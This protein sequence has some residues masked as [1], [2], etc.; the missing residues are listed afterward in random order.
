MEDDMGEPHPPL[1]TL[2]VA[3]SG[4]SCVNC[5]ILIERKFKNIAG[6]ERVKVDHARGYAEVSHAGDLDIATLQRAI[7]EDGYAVSP[8]APSRA[9]A[10]DKNSTRDYA[11]II[12]IFAVLLGTLFALQHFDLLPH[13]L[14][15]SDTMGYGLVF[16]IGLV[17]SVSSCM[18]VT[19]GLLVATAA[20]Y[21]QSS[22]DLSP[23][24]RLKP[25][26]YF[27]A[28]RIVSYMLFG[29]AIGAL[30]SALTLSAETNGL[31]TIA[32]SVIMIVLG[33]QMLGFIPG[34]GR[35]LPSLPKSF[36]RRIHDLV[37]RQTVRSAFAFGAM[38]FF[39]PCG[40]T[41]ALQLYV[42][43]KGSFI[44]GALT[45]LA[46]ALGTLPA[47]LSLSALSSFAKGLVQKRFLR[48]AGAAVIILGVLNIEY[49]LVLAGLGASAGPAEA[50]G[51]TQAT[52]INGKQVVVMKVVD[53][54]YIPNVFEVKQNTP[55]EWRIDASGAAGCGQYLI[56][57]RL[58]IRRL[59]SSV[60]TTV[61]AFTPRAPG[62]YMFNCGM[63]MMTPGSKFIV[64]PDTPGDKS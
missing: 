21:N 10:R 6:V 43:G 61:I 42:L 8:W 32:A 16:L 57:P 51:P 54:D 56:A 41:Q 17:A 34:F 63:G 12:G 22:P 45:M 38:T 49:G 60:S 64:R 7:A 53:F 24:E 28:G 18:A 47:L 15:V 30:G 1:Q 11:E 55:V 46:F 29:G 20:K 4:M 58:G 33:L 40:F 36:A 50:E 14:A 35:F 52:V 27:N 13:G 3:V 44:T 23:A 59:L 9:T 48:L 62:E 25:H 26:L 2:M 39:L 37:A 19:G 31:F 5:E